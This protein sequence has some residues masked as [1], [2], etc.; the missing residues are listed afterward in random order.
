LHNIYDGQ[1]T[2]VGSATQGIISIGRLVEKT[3]AFVQLV[4][5]LLMVMRLVFMT[6]AIAVLMT[7]VVLPDIIVKQPFYTLVRTIIRSIDASNGKENVLTESW[8]L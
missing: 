8:S 6:V 2:I 3:H 5:L 4:L 7:M 1:T